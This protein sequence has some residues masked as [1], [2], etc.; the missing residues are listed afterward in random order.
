[1]KKCH[2]SGITQ[3]KMVT[4]AAE[5]TSECNEKNENEHKALQNVSAAHFA[6]RK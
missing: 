2:A 6:K 3:F 5:I 4:T 1:M